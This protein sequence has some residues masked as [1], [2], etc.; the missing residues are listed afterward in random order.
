[1]IVATPKGETIVTKHNILGLLNDLGIKVND[2]LTLEFGD[3]T[4]LSVF[5]TELRKCRFSQT[6][7]DKLL[8]IIKERLD[9]RQS[10]TNKPT[11]RFFDLV[12]EEQ[13]RAEKI[14][15]SIT[16]H[17]EAIALIRE[18]YLE[19]EAEVFRRKIDRHEALRECTQLGYLCKKYAES[20]L[21][22]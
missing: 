10:L 19:L 18:E 13:A 9:V 8:E 11:T 16:T 14:H 17:H 12:L 6:E 4:K 22:D 21:I 5:E 1:M 20:L 15:P 2:I 7:I 3:V